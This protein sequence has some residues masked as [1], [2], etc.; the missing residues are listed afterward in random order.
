MCGINFVKKH[1]R[2]YIFA[3]LNPACVTQSGRDVVGQETRTGIDSMK[4]KIILITILLCWN[5]VLNA[6]RSK[7]NDHSIIKWTGIKNIKVNETDSVSFISFDGAFYI[8]NLPYYFEKIKIES[9]YSYSAKISD[10]VFEECTKEEMKVIKTDA[11]KSE[12]IIQSSV[13]PEKK[14][15]YLCVS[16]FPFRINSSTGK[17]EKLVSFKIEP[18]QGQAIANAKQKLMYAQ[19][20]VLSSG[21]WYKIAVTDNKVYKL[22]YDNLLSLGIDV[23]SVDPKNIRIYGNGGGMLPE[24]NNKSRY[25]D[26]VENSIFV[27]G[28]SDGVFDNTDYILF[29]GESPVKWKYSSND[30][31]FHH[32]AN[33]YSN[34][35]YYF[36]STDLGSGK[37]ISQQSSTTQP[38]NKF[39]TKFND[40]ACHEKDSINLI[41][42]GKE[43][44][45]E[46]FDILTSY[47]FNFTFPN[48]DGNSMIFIQSDIA[49]KYTSPNYYT[50]N[51]NG[52]SYTTVIGGVSGLYEF[53][54]A[55]TDTMSFF[56]GSSNINV[57]VTKTTSNAIGWMNYIELNATRDIIL[58]NYPLSFRS[59]TSVGLGNISEYTVS[60]AGSGVKIWEVTNPLD[61]KEQQFTLSGNNAV[62]RLSSDTLREFV[63]FNGMNFSTPILAGKFDNQNLH[64]LGQTDLIIVSHPD[65]LSEAY[66]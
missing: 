38:A 25:D 44:Y 41:K 7:N 63:A 36:I 27:K 11:L 54:A 29:Y 46:N 60:N 30:K 43:W 6:Q 45:G 1:K 18:V 47:S 48:I 56:S 26:L 2:F 3:R 12:I 14:Q 51:A 32:Q 13:T 61:A 65:F 21:K 8:D 59:I 10:Q 39:I 28:E 62:F 16:F 19:N 22:T 15:P 23:A 17:I 5:F 66:R 31:K 42:S 9:N 40:Y 4:I 55:K 53:A 58:S 64:A 49:G 35:T 57:T 24:E 52:H 34:Y 37:R 20:S 50:V 33:Y